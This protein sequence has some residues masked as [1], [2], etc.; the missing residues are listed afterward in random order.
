MSVVGE[1]VTPI[2]L[3]RLTLDSFAGRPVAVLGLARSGIALARFFADRGATVTVY[4]GRSRDQLERELA[5]IDATGARLLLG[6]E[7]DPRDALD[8]QALIARTTPRRASAAFTC[9][10]DGTSAAVYGKC[11][12]SL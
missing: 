1:A 6:P 9:R 3:E 7:V 12:S 11:R 5:Q 4:D 8:S 2:D 10:M